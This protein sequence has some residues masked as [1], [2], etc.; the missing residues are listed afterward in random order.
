MKKIFTLL[1]FLTCF[2]GANAVEIVDVETD[3]STATSWE[4]GWLSN[5]DLI[6]FEDG[7]IHF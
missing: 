1:A 4:H 3:F 2:L 7:C 5:A 6:T